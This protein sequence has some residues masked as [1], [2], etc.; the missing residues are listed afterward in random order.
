MSADL[1]RKILYSLVFALLI[2]IGL[3]LWSDWGQVS[4]AL[5]QFPW[6]WLPVV[7]GLTA[8]N[9]SGR[10]LR[11]H[12][13]LRRLGTPIRLR[14]SA[15]VFGVGMLMVMTPGKAG[16]FLKSYMVR[17]VA[18]TPMSKTAPIILAERL[19]DGAAMLLL[20]SA[21]LFAFPDRTARLIALIVFGGF[22]A[23]GSS[24]SQPRRIRPR[25]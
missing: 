23:S 13:Y 3:A 16:E 15:R 25:T 5:A 7:L 18:G 2:Y 12:W 6:Q 19:T 14:D 11:W 17:N 9:Y 22:L 24:R 1:R 8:I 21:G 20:A 4:A 10:L